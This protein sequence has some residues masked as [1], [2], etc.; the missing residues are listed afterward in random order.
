[1]CPALALNPFLVLGPVGMVAVG[2]VAIAYWRRRGRAAPKFFA[3]GGAFWAAAIAIKLA[4]DLTVTTP[5]YLSWV[6]WGELS[7]LVLLGV[8]VGLRTGVLECLIPYLGFRT[9]RFR[10]TSLDEATA[11]GVGFGAAEAIVIAI[12]SLLQMVVFLLNPSILGTLPAGQAQAIEAQLSQPTWMALPA[13]WERA[14]VIL[15]HVFATLLAFVAAA[16]SRWMPLLAA[17]LFKSALDGPLPLMQ[18][19]LGSSWLGTMIIEVFVA[20]MG[21]IALLGII[22]VRGGYAGGDQEKRL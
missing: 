4:M 5:L 16:R 22:R 17:A 19:Y 13:I 6:G 12:P 3:L 11:V 10:G 14:F 9:N 1:M 21:L 2:I 8:Y 15:V 7:A 20:V 18:G